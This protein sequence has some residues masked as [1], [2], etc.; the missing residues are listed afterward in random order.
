Y[1][2]VRDIVE[3]FA[4]HVARTPAAPAVMH[5]DARLSYRELDAWSHRIA[6]LLR[7]AGAGAEQRVGLYME[8]THATVAALLGILKSGAAYVPIDATY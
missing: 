8:R 1:P 4:A 5:E 2:V 3:W 7:S 6:A